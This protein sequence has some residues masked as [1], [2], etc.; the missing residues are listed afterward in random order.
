MGQHLIKR[1]VTGIDTRLYVR[2]SAATAHSFKTRQSV[3]VETAISI[4]VSNVSGS[5]IA[6]FLRLFNQ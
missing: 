3:R 5:V 2:G 1:G 6:A 4:F